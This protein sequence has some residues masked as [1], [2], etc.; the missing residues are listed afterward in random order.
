M[1][2][3][4]CMKWITKLTLI[5]SV[6]VLLSIGVVPQV[7][8][9]T[10][11]KSKRSELSNT[12]SDESNTPAIVP[13]TPAPE[14]GVYG[15][16]SRRSVIRQG[17]LV[18]AP[19]VDTLLRDSLARDSVTQELLAENDSLSM[20]RVATENKE[21]MALLNAASVSVDDNSKLNERHRFFSDSMSL[22]N[23]AWASA[24]VPGFGQIYNKQ[25]W[26][27][28][29]VY[30]AMAGSI[31]LFVNENKKYQ[32]LK[33]R[34]TEMTL[35]D[36]SRT[37][38]LN[39]LQ[40][41]MIRSN[42]RRQIYLGTTIASYIYSIGDAA[43][44]YSTNDASDVKRATTLA[45]ICPGAGQI[46]NKSYW[47]VPFVVGGF[48]MMGYVFDWNNRGYKRFKKAYTLRA[49]YDTNPD[50]YPDGSSDEFSGRYSADYLQSLRDSYRR[51]RDMS[52]IFIVGL[53]VLQIVDAHVDAHFND[54][55]VSDDLSM[56]IE[57]MIG[58]SYSP[59]KNSNCVTYGFNV[60]LKF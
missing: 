32:P 23:V 44:N 22:S 9:Q 49:D 12:A 19:S 7:S 13:G 29:I 8:A 21:G 30:G 5:L 24:V 35:T 6:T 2:Y 25:Y 45:T 58:N 10:Q 57:P 37:E 15:R 53:Y 43:V 26:K 14:G 55:D 28:P 33:D 48:A 42:T 59:A 4:N 41:D 56:N 52:V 50:N 18:S 54:F 16:S 46:Y 17:M 34:Y 39:E 38:E 47:K 51:N 31:L 11:G 27:L 1:G 60:G 40:A 3:Y 20:N 36:T